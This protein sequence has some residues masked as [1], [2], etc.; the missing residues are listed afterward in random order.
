MT[1]RPSLRMSSWPGL[2]ISGLNE[3]TVRLAQLVLE[4]RGVVPVEVWVE[5]GGSPFH[6][7][8]LR[9]LRCTHA[10][11]GR[12]VPALASPTELHVDRSTLAF[13]SSAPSHVGRCS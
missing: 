9:T 3:L 12:F 13:A 1:L 4:G 11:Q 5:R 10:H 8:Y 6:G 7:Y 2:S